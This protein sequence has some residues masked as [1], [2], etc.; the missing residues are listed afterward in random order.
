MLIMLFLTQEMIESGEKFPILKG[1]CRAYGEVRTALLHCPVD[2]IEYEDQKEIPNQLKMIMEPRRMVLK[3]FTR[4]GQYPIQEII[5][6][7]AG[8]VIFVHVGRGKGQF[9]WRGPHGEQGT[10]PFER[11][12][13]YKIPRGV[14]VDH[15]IAIRCNDTKGLLAFDILEYPQKKKPL[16]KPKEQFPMKDMVGDIEGHCYMAPGMMR[17]ERRKRTIF[18][19]ALCALTGERIGSIV[20]V[21][22]LDYEGRILL[23]TIVCPRT[24]IRKY[25]SNIHGLTEQEIAQGMDELE[26]SEKIRHL[27]RGKIVIGCDM[28][29]EIR[30]IKGEIAGERDILESPMVRNKIHAGRRL[31]LYEAALV[32]GAR[33]DKNQSALQNA[34]IIGRIYREIEDEWE[35]FLAQ[36]VEGRRRTTKA[37]TRWELG[38]GTSKDTQRNETRIVIAP[39]KQSAEEVSRLS[40]LEISNAWAKERE[41]QRR[42][43]EKLE[44]VRKALEKERTRLQEERLAL[45]EARRRIEEER[46][47]REEEERKLREAI[48]EVDPYV[49]A[50]PRGDL[51]V[52]KRAEKLRRSIGLIGE[53]PKG[54]T[55]KI[56][57]DNY[58]KKSLKRID[59][60]AEQAGRSEADNSRKTNVN[61]F[62]KA[63]RNIPKKKHA[64]NQAERTGKSGEDMPQEKKQKVQIQPS[65]AWDDPAWDSSDDDLEITQFIDNRVKT[66][67]QVTSEKKR[68][69]TEDEHRAAGSS[70]GHSEQSRQRAEPASRSKP[71][72]GALSIPYDDWVVDVD[73][74]DELAEGLA[75]D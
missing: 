43:T 51:E 31:T 58:K 19:S 32:F 33:Q 60:N 36:E 63:G 44:K 55:L 24:Q 16:E 39:E 46:E 57:F 64:D 2:R 5:G 62:G 74:A 14:T 28:E 47:R 38:E 17:E 22:I 3:M 48:L 42:E 61:Q 27:T 71:S 10:Q 11:G 18:L 23:A 59:D 56:T 6:Q 34:N 4:E 50:D 41:L 75:D 66:T 20:E 15:E 37:P 54:E 68:A 26:A 53:L 13:T 65:R 73:L 49:R 1:P 52:K 45:E 21:A 29:G 40:R 8:R 69:T 25:Q 12:Y 9:A 72:Q 67:K 35:E 7:T 70:A 30:M